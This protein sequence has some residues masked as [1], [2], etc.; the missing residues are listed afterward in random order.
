MKAVCVG[1]GDGGLSQLRVLRVFS[2]WGK[3]GMIFHLPVV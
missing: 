3:Y 2:P 1:A